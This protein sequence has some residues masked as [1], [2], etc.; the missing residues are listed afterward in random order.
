MSSRTRDAERLRFINE[1]TDWFATTI[2]GHD[3]Q[4]PVPGLDWT[5]AELGAHVAGLPRFYRGLAERRDPQPVP[6]DFT[7]FAS[8]VLN[9]FESRDL[10]VQAETLR[11]DMGDLLAF[12]GD[13][14]DEPFNFWVTRHPVRVIHGVMLNELLVHGRDLAGAGNGRHDITR[15]Q[16][17][18]ALDGV[19]PLSAHFVDPIAARGLTGVVHVHLR[20]GNGGDGGAGADWTQ[21]FD[22]GS[23]VVTEGRPSR[24]DV[25][26]NADPVTFQLLGVGRI[27]PVLPALTGKML[28]YGRK[29]WLAARLANVFQNV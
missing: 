22:N 16:A 8:D 10:T 15:A 11:S 14:P 7:A 13:D 1:A 21:T 12:Y 6:D 17:L 19:I 26:V 18:A 23:L 27:G 2:V 29:P 9:R 20:G 28:A 25:R 4:A 24:A 5:V 3:P